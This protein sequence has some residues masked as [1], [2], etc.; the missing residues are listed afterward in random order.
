MTDAEFLRNE[1]QRCRWLAARIT[2]GDVAQSLLDMAKECDQRA[3][4]LESR[5]EPPRAP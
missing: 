1:A 2:S 3:E 4:A 5:Q